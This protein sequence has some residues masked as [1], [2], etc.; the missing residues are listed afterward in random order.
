M[1]TPFVSLCPEITRANALTLMDWLE[2]EDVTRFLSDSRHVSRSIEQVIGRVQLPILTHLFNQGGRFF[3]AYDQHDVPVGFVRLVKMGPDCEMVLVIGDRDNWGRKFGASA[4][5][6]GMKLAFFEMR[7]EKLIAKIHPENVRSLN[8]F[9]RSGF[10]PESETPA[11]KSLV[12]SSGRYL[13]LLRERP[14]VHTADIYITEIDKARLRSL[15]DL[16]QGSD[17]F[18]LEHEIE[19]AIVVDP[20]KV[21]EDV[22]TMN[23]RALLQVNDEEVEVALVYPEEADD[24]AGKLSVCSG[25]GTAI[26]GY[27]EGDAFS[28]RIPN[29]TCHIR[30]GKVLYQPEAA[31]DFHL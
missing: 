3:M 19:R 5:R 24:R 21:A 17:I 9:L 22:V 10:L 13:R 16:E 20:R 29:R 14:A 26:L 25:I 12:M 8:A 18:E 1:N 2:D 7:A 6:E 30:I 15:I 31:G 28:W 11:R 4:I 27:K 23:S